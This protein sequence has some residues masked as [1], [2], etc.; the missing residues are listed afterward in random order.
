MKQF[1]KFLFASCLG[2][3]LGLFLLGGI[4]MM[5]VSSQVSNAEKGAT[6]KANTIL[7]LTLSSPIPEQ[8]NN[9][10]VDPYQFNTDKTLGLLDMVDAIERAKDDDN[11]KGIYLELGEPAAGFASLSVLRQALEDFKTPKDGDTDGKF[12][13]AYG[14]YYSQKSYYL[15]SAADEIY[16]NPVGGVEFKGFGGQLMFYKGMLD[17]L[18]IKMQVYYAGKFKS[19]TEPFRRTNMS[20]ESKLQVRQYMEQMYG[21]VLEDISKSRNISVKKLRQIADEYALR[22]ADDAIKYKFVDGKKYKDE[23]I[24]LLKGKLGI[25]KKKDI[26]AM[27]LTGYDASNPEKKDF[28]T[29]NKIALVIAEGTIVDGEG[30]NGSTGGDKY[31]KLLREIRQDDKVKAIVMRVNSP[32]GSG[33]ASEK[34]WRELMLAKEQGIT[35]VA[36]MSDLAASGGYYIACMADKIVAEPNTITGSIGVFGTIPSMEGFLKEKIG[37]TMDTIKTGKY[38]SGI[39]PFI[40]ISDDEG[41]IIQQ[42]VNEFYAT[43]LARVA[44]GRKMDTAAVHKV[45]QGRVWTGKKAKEIG[46]VDELGGLDRAMEIAKEL[47][48]LNEYRVIE[49]PGVKDPVQQI[50]EQFTGKKDKN[51]AAKT[52]IKSELGDMYKYYDEMKAI[53]NM[54]GIQARMPYTIELY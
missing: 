21:V 42:G 28:K 30:E 39:S 53:K 2:T 14:D 35:V 24:D 44:D 25:D 26:N 43:F 15:A 18:G 4:I 37:V 46:L 13:V 29:K 5:I 31:A 49:Y 1:F 12:I 50:I 36:S 11:I 45:A 32:G 20:E 27:S 48:G 8:S 34:I 33:L 6:V 23:I 10:A 7:K 19:A 41:Q 38:S 22:N 9:I 54:T 16:V 17:K 52:L 51:A 40:N 3:A 47:A